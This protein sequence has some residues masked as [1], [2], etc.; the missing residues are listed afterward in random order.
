VTNRKPS[1]EFEFDNNKITLSVDK[2]IDFLDG[3]KTNNLFGLPF[4]LCRS[5]DS[6]YKSLKRRLND[7]QKEKLESSFDRAKN[8]SPHPCASLVIQV[9]PPPKQIRHPPH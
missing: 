6:E 7:S 8:C 1:Y 3:K 9:S 5:N 2:I 4:V